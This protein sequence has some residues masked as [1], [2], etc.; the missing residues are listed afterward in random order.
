MKLSTLDPSLAFRATADGAH[1]QMKRLHQTQAIDFLML[2]DEDEFCTSETL[3]WIQYRIGNIIRGRIDGLGLDKLSGTKGVR[4]LECGTALRRAVTAGSS[5]RAFSRS[6]PRVDGL[7]G[8][9]VIVG[10]IDTGIDFTHPDFRNDDGSTRILSIWDHRLQPTP[11]ER[12][13]VEFG[14]G[15]TYTQVDINR[16]LSSNDPYQIVRHQD[17]DEVGHGTH[18]A[19]IAAGNGRASKAIQ[20]LDGPS[21]VAPGSKLIV[22][23]MNSASED[24]TAIGDTIQLIDAAVFI[25]EQARLA[26]MAAVI[27][28]SDGDCLGSHDGSSLVET[29]LD[30]LLRVPG[31]AIAKSA[32]NQR[33]Q[34]RRAEVSVPANGSSVVNFKIEQKMKGVGIVDC[35]WR[36]DFEIDFIVRAPTNESFGPLHP[37]T[38]VRDYAI[39]GSQID[40][41]FIRSDPRNGLTHAQI[42]IKSTDLVTSSVWQFELTNHDEHSATVDM[43]IEPRS[44][45]PRF[46]GPEVSESVT[47]TIP[48]TGRTVMV[49]GATQFTDDGNE[50]AAAFSG[51]GPTRDGRPKPTCFAPGVDVVSC[52]AI[53]PNST[54]YYRVLSGTSMAAPLAAGVLALAFQACAT[55]RQDDILDALLQCSSGNTLPSLSN[56]KLVGDLIAELCTLFRNRQGARS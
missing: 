19:G 8:S 33:D 5:G 48:G 34:S 46:I 38:V 28:I 56:S 29:A 39:G 18:V 10:I 41:Y 37:D 6:T 42:R 14:Y 12:G 55:V 2:I 3:P 11:G 7:D 13:P 44:Q 15:V 53:G 47:V 31:R 26:G 36:A 50:I 27:N 45:S 32:G 16:A 24:E 43:W 20:A 40:I 35:W 23:A 9:G 52:A 49:V 22:V 21:G 54:G 4:F 30:A 17:T 51:L 1:P 25:F